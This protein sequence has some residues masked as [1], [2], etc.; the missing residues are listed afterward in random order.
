MN[1]YI[2]TNWTTQINEQILETYDLPRLSHEEIE[3]L[4]RPLTSKE[5][6]SVIKN[7][8]QVKTQDQMLALVN[9]ILV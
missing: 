3:N 7:S 4:N 1:S 8:Q 6:E 2:P 9:S 5:V